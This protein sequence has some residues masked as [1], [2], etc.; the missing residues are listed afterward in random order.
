MPDE[1]FGRYFRALVQG[2]GAHVAVGQ[3]EPGAGEGVG[4]LGGV[5]VEAAGNLLV[6]WVHA[7]RE[8]GRGHHGRVLLAGVVRVWD[9]VLGLHVLGHPLVRAGWA[10]GQLPLVAKQHVEVAVVPGG[11]VG[12]PG[13]FNAAGGGVHALAAAKLVD[14]AQALRFQRGGFGLRADQ[15]GVARAVGLAEGVAA[16]HQ[17]HGF[18]VVHG[19]AGK[20]F[21]HIAAAGHGVGLAVR[22][23][24]VHVDQAHLH[25]G[26]RVFQVALAAVAAVRLVAG[27]QPFGFRTPIDVFFRLPDV[28]TATGKTEGLEAHGFQ[29]HVAR[30]DHQVG[31]RD[32]VAVLLLDGPQQAAGLVQVAVVGPAV[33]RGKTLV[34]R[35]CAATAIAGAVG[36]CAVPGHANEQAAVVAPVGRPPVLRVGHQHLQVCLEG[37]V[38]QLFKSSG[39]VKVFAQR[40]RCGGVLVQDAQVQLVGP[41]VAVGLAGGSSLCA[42]YAGLRAGERAFGFVAHG[43]LLLKRVSCSTV[44]EG[45]FNR[46][47]ITIC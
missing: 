27:G 3:L 18:F 38:V 25:G 44:H 37:G 15:L 12:L 22:A 39:V 33:Q 47:R 42:L 16:G 10:L 7:Q 31:P 19:H 30:Q 23:F 36:A 21:A 45:Y 43:S 20:G 1:V 9:H 5:L 13:A 6:R 2:L 46:W 26:Q 28:G 41:P 29:R 32:G 35:A 4:K 40:V 11:G 17:G 8:V 14:P 24:G 34:A